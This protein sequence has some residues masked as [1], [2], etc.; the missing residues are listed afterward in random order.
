M[1]SSNAGRCW[2][3][4]VGWPGLS[5][6]RRGGEG[7]NGNRKR[8]GRGGRGEVGWVER[9]SLGKVEGNGWVGWKERGG[10]DGRGSVD[11]MEGERLGWGWRV[12]GWGGRGE[13]RWGG[14]GEVGWGKVGRKRC[15]RRGEIVWG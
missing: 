2:L 10:W 8:L 3:G 5:T 4:A 13:C 7:W 9:E 12:F 15:G 14:K 11:G 6:A 1:S